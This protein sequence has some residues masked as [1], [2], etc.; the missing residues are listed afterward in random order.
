MNIN[1]LDWSDPAMKAGLCR[2]SIA[3]LESM[4]NRDGEPIDERP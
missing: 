3:A 2:E 4:G 1:I